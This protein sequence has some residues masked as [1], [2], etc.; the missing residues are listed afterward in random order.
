MQR[1][2][3]GA[4]PRRGRKF[5][6]EHRGGAEGSVRSTQVR[7][8]RTTEATPRNQGGPPPQG[9]AVEE[10]EHCQG[11]HRGMGALPRPTP[12]NHQGQGRRRRR[13]IGALPRPRNGS[14]AEA[15]EWEHCRGRGM[16]APPR[17]T[18]RN[19]ST[20]EAEAK[21]WEHR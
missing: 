19:G 17:P 20:A 1:N 16:G 14:T 10:W 2:R 11:R 13:G 4:P 18:P 21:E 6:A 3:G 8:R 9:K 15:E 5:R 7:P 12:R